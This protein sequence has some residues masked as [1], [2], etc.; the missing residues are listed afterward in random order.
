MDPYSYKI[1]NDYFDF[2]YQP[3]HVRE[4]F[5][6]QERAKPFSIKSPDKSNKSEKDLKKKKKKR[7]FD[8]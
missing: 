8:L 4:V 3:P 6:Y 2:V 1:W 5:Q 7:P